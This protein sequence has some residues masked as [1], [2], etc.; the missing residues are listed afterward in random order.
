MTNR[1]KVKNSLTFRL[2]TD[3]ENAQN[4]CNVGN[5]RVVLDTIC[6]WIEQIDKAD[7]VKYQDLPGIIMPSFGLS[8]F[9]L[10]G[11]INLI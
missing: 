10:I 3:K 4:H 2:F 11:V 6:G 1:N 9:G 5:G 8:M 7:S